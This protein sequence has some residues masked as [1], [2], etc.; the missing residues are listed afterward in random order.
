MPKSPFYQVV[1]SHNNRNITELI[2]SFTY[3]DCVEQDNLLVLRISDTR[4]AL[5]DDPDLQE[6]VELIFHFGYLQG[7][8]S[9]KREARITNVEPSYGNQLNLTIK[10]SDQGVVMKK[11]DNSKV[12]EKKTS[13]EIVEAIAAKHGLKAVVDKTTKKHD[14]MPQGNKSDYDFCKHLAGQ[15]TDGSFQFFLR[16]KELHFKKRDLKKSPTKN[17]TWN[18]GDGNILG[19]RPKSKELTKDGASKETSVVAVDPLTNQPIV[20]KANNSTAKDDTKLGDYPV[21]Y[22]ADGK[23][24]S[25]GTGGKTEN[26]EELTGKKIVTAVADKEEADN[27]ANNKKKKA[28]MDDMSAVLDVEMDPDLSSDDIITIS[29]VGQKFG[30]NWYVNKVSFSIQGGSAATCSMD[31]KK[32]AGSVPTNSGTDKAKQTNK[33]VGPNEADKKKAVEVYKYD[34]NGNRIK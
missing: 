17:F 7:R 20:S 14:M 10:A 15:E 25:S 24:V 21:F 29:N 5:V 2:S 16:G 26:A 11:G 8:I 9:P 28:A 1:V 12:W 32:N 4:V 19:F 18:K 30:G 23:K 3:E 13:S 33:E 22:N 34:G 31:L 27:I 6:G